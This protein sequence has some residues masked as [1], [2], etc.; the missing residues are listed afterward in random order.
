MKISKIRIKNLFG[1]SEIELDGKDR[2]FIGDNATGKTSVIDCIRLALRNKSDRDYVIKGGAEEGEVYIETDSGLTIK[3]LFRT[4][5]AD[6]SRIKQDGEK[7][8]AGVKTEAFLR[9]IFSEIQLDPVAF[10]DMTPQEQNRTI[11]DLIDFKWDMD[12]IKDQFGE[13]PPDINW[14][15]NILAVLHDI[16]KEG[17]Y[18]Y[19][20][21]Q[22][23][24]RELKSNHANIEEIG[25][26][27]PKDYNSKY[28]RG[29]DLNVKYSELERIRQQNQQIAAARSIVDNKDS[30]LRGIDANM[31]IEIDAL[32]RA[33]EVDIQQS[34]DRIRQL[35]EEIRSIRQDIEHRRSG[36]ADKLESIRSKFKAQKAKFEAEI[37]QYGETAAKEPVDITELQAEVQQIIKMREYGNEYD[38]M[39]RLQEQNTRLQ[40]NVEDLTRK[41]EK[42]RFLPAE[43]LQKSSI[44]VKGITIKDGSPLIN[45][46]PISNL[47]EGEKLILCID[48]A[49]AKPHGLQ[50]L[51]IDGIERLSLHNRQVLYQRLKQKGIQFM[52]TRTTESPD[53]TVIEL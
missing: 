2:E 52:A 18:Y 42:A 3:R 27:L 15:Q 10:L 31:Q 9:E 5:K 30:K 19:E 26:D 16:Q 44:P 28:W 38:R 33:H 40:Q 11:L 13:I 47:S 32:Q 1:L 22:D 24:N 46:L 14:S 36:L 48:V 17:G 25:K 43:I 45:G 29:I 7:G 8:A 39:V 51:L 23:I 4:K 35:E 49:I 50:I 6:Y 41:I 37:E 20:K 53:L 12:W 21:R 34:E